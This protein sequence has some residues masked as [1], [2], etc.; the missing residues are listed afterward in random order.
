MVKGAYLLYEGRLTAGLI[1]LVK[2]IPPSRRYQLM[3]I[4]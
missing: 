1:N 4:T 2:T 3:P